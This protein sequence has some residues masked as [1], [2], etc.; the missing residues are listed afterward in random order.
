MKKT[1][2]YL[3]VSLLLVSTLLA[4]CGG[5]PAAA[6]TSAPTAAATEAGPTD[7]PAAG[8][9]D[10][11]KVCYLIPDTANPFLSQLTEAV[12]AKF[13]EDGVEVLISGAGGN[14]TTQFN[15]IENC[16]SSRVD[17]MIIMAALEP[18]GVE[19]SVL[20]A[21]EAGIKVMGVPVDEQGPY[22]A[23][24]H[25]DQ[26]EI[27]TKMA[28]M[29]CDFINA[30]YPDAADDSIE[31]A[32]IG[33]KGTELLKKRTEG[34]ETVDDCPKAKLVQFVDVPETTISQGVT[35]AENIFTA[36]PNV[37]VILVT[38]DG[39]AQGVAE[40]MSA[41]AP[42]N[43]SQYAV[44]SG[45]VS[46]EMQEVIQGCETAYRGAVAIGGGPEE[47]AQ[48]T[49]D[50]V[51]KML[52]GVEFPAETLDPLVTITCEAAAQPA[53][54]PATEGTGTIA[55]VLP[56]L[57][58][59]L[60]LGFQDA[61]QQGLGDRY[62]VQVASADGDPNRQ[63]AQIENYTAM[64]VDFM[65]VMAV[66]PTSIL[67]RL[68]AAK[69]AGITIL[70]AGGDPGDP[71]AY[72]SVMMMNQFLSGHYAAYMAKQWVD[73]T[74]PDAAPGSI[75]TAIFESTLNPEAVARTAGLH[76]IT[77]PY[78]KNA[79]GEYVDAAGNVVGEADRV[80]NP[81]YSP[82]VNVVQTVQAEMFQAGQTA[83]QNVLTTNPN[84]KLVI[85]YAGDGAMGASQAIM[86]EY[87]KGAGGSVIDDL[88]KVAVFSV[89]LLGAEGPAVADSS[90]G[91]GVFRGTIRFG[92]DLVGRTMEY[93]TKMLNGEEVPAIIWDDLD[94]VTAVDGKLYA[95]PVESAT[96]LVVPTAE[97]QELILPGPPQ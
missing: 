67:P 79:A 3:L 17:A 95:V 26:R 54:E 81:A 50:I 82:A 92:G 24:M 51:K 80:E 86:D 2:L 85:A 28:G 66:E 55:V 64:G 87:A 14:A 37:K 62:D 91:K 13:E 77:E 30:T 8:S 49:Y 83:M 76:M 15:Q 46:P 40:A 29:A 22:D 33:T 96:V 68:E 27:G 74:Y 90:I 60:M 9:I 47:L 71:A 94:L 93:A 41:Y 23:I 5:E 65:F 11:K 44:F 57:D 48:S 20:E 35:A 45:D 73:K 63:A 89:G 16:I 72:T 39:G 7:A 53:A 84:V 21:K 25:T 36:N 75:E 42:D 43:L 52:M 6:P 59:P 70:V 38:G 61:F 18:E 69:E 12:K 58:N 97:P 31:V 78:L 19:A 32:V 4:A 10:G 1:T 34:M 56:A 88:N